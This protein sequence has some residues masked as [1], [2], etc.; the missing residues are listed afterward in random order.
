MSLRVKAKIKGAI[1][2]FLNLSDFNMT[3]TFIK[4][5]IKPIEASMAPEM[6]AAVALGE[7]K[8]DVKFIFD[9]IQL[10]LHMYIDK[11][12][13]PPLLLLILF[14]FATLQKS[15]DMDFLWLKIWAKS[16]EAFIKVEK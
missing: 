8:W 14:V 3:N 16:F 4:F 1:T 7:S 11:C 12:I 13:H 2:L 10:K 6:A 5:S 15:L 9:R